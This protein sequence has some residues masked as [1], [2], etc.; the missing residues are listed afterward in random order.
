MNGA[1][2]SLTGI[3]LLEAYGRPPAG[4]GWK[5]GA[6]SLSI[7]LAVV[8][9]LVSLPPEFWRTRTTS[10][11]GIV[12]EVRRPTPLV[13]PPFELTQKEP[14]QGKVSKEVNLEGLLPKPRLQVPPGPAAT[15]RPAFRLPAPQPAVPQ[16]LPAL[17][18]PPKVLPQVAATLPV[19]QP[20]AP[21]PGPPPQIQVRDEK[22]KLAFENPAAAYGPGRQPVRGLSQIPRPQTS[23]QEAMRGAARGMRA[24]GLV[25]G[26]P[27]EDGGAS[28]ALHLPGQPGRQGSRLELLSD[29]KG[30][31]FRPYLTLVLSAVRRN[32]FA[33]IPESAKLGRRGRVQLQFAISRDGSVPKLVISTPSGTDS[34]DRAAVAGVSASNPFP[35]LPAEFPGNEIRLQFTFLYNLR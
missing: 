24:G 16:P 13:A 6:A 17:P 3:R 7:H 23:V 4:P 5:A 11:G 27:S 2:N 34:L 22:P 30:V 15:A 19:G 10:G 28:E 18:E 9:M 32:W 33:V 20:N 35:P 25:V 14:N 21:L 8:V 29:P 12:L 26:D 1:V 31:D